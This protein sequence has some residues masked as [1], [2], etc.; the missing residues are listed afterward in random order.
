M[1]SKHV[2]LYCVVMPRD[3]FRPSMYVYS[4]QNTGLR[5]R[6][7][8]GGKFHCFMFPR[9][10]DRQYRCVEKDTVYLLKC[11][12]IRTKTVSQIVP[13]ETLNCSSNCLSNTRRLACTVSSIT[14]T[15]SA[16]VE[17]RQLVHLSHSRDSH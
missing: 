9:M 1:L 2:F 3:R 16:D 10:S 17:G 4:T 6:G 12:T 13:C 7:D 15:R 11:S 5:C 14:G 8:G